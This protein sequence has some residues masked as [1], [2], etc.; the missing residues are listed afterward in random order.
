MII[1][2]LVDMT[3]ET[4][5]NLFTNAITWEKCDMAL[6]LNADAIKK[7][8]AIISSDEVTTD[9][10]KVAQAKLEKLRA[11]YTQLKAQ[12]EKVTEDYTTVLTTIASAHNEHTANDETAVRNILRLSC[13]DDNSKFFK[14]AII[15]KETFESFY[16]SMVSLHDMDSDEIG[17]NGLRHYSDKSNAVADAL[18]KDIQGLIKKMFS[19][20]IENEYTKKVNVKFNKTDLAC[21][22]ETFVTG[23][24]VDMKNSKKTGTTV[25]GVSFRYAIEKVQKKDKEPEYKGTRFKETLAKL[26]FNKLFA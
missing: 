17:A 25:E 19:I 18:E 10:I 26:A 23:L 9:E 13:C 3:N 11:E 5:V 16:D 6:T 20:S 14:L 4:L 24:S 7:Q 1:K 15:T 2:N 12:Q 22:H 21:V 8:E